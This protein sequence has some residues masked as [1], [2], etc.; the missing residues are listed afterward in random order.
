MPEKQLPARDFARLYARFSAPVAA[1]DCGAKCAPY[2][3]NGVPFCCDTRHMV[4]AA[5]AAEWEYLKANTDLWHPWEA[6]QP[7][8]TERLQA[9]TPAGQVLI[10]CLG[11][12]CCQRN[13]RSL[14]C[15][16][17]PFFPYIDAGGEFIGMSYYWEY[18]DRCWVV[19]NLH[20]VTSEYR[21]QFIAAY[22]ELFERLPQEYETFFQYGEWMRQVFARRRRAIPLIHRLGGTFKLSPVSGR[23]RR[24][25]PEDFPKFGPYR[26]AALLPFPD[27][28]SEG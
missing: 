27:E 18:E 11:H 8:E 17:F 16:S 6:D 10:S 7:G 15:R 19:N 14:A 25:R 1:F 28:V 3:E 13:F 9:E 2:N 22:D 12:T 20:V 21:R 26:I 5:Y 24:A 23:L 4:P